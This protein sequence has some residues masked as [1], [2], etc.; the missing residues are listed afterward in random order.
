MALS[1]FSK[2]VI[3]MSYI[4]PAKP[5]KALYAGN[6]YAKHAATVTKQAVVTSICGDNATI[7]I[8]AHVNCKNCEVC[9]S[10]E[11][12]MQVDNQV[13]AKVGDTVEI[14]IGDNRG[15]KI[16]FIEIMMP[17]LSL[18]AGLICGYVFAFIFK[19]C[20]FYSMFICSLVFGIA[21]TANAV[22]YDRKNRTTGKTSIKAVI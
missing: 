4:S 20:E 11:I 10:P 9:G 1:N 2:G 6:F 13:N 22:R 15:I 21:T 8:G 17:F 14:D 18:P 5:D 7:K 12:L 19:T 3:I 16:V